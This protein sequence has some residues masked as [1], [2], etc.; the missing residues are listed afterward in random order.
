MACPQNCLD[1][2]IVEETC[3]GCVYG[4]FGQ[5]AILKIK[6]I[7]IRVT[8]TYSNTICEY[9]RLSFWRCDFEIV[10]F[11]S[12]ETI[13]FL[14]LL[15]MFSKYIKLLIFLFCVTNS[16][17][18]LGCPFQRNYGVNCSKPCPRNC[19]EGRCHDVDGI[20][21]GCTT[22]YTGSKCEGYYT[23]QNHDKIEI[24]LYC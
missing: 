10:I 5:D 4:V 6:V 13:I 11:S 1:G 3:L 21:L 7:I 9:N 12:E 19:M 2:Y 24:W 18:L 8:I 20:C 23:D 17:L 14:L 22:G 15:D 16:L